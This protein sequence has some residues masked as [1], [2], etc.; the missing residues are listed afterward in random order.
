[1]HD[2]ICALPQIVLGFGYKVVWSDMDAVWLE[3]FLNLMPRGLDY[4]GIDDSEVPDEQVSVC[5]I[6]ALVACYLRIPLVRQ[7]IG[8]AARMRLTQRSQNFAFCLGPL[9]RKTHY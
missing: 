6:V 7:L 1:M 2:L 3:N 5:V 8:T 9:V 4:V